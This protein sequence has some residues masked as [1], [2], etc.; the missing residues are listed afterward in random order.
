MNMPL[1]P[2][3]IGDEVHCLLIPIVNG[4]LLLPTVTVAEMIPYRS[5]QLKTDQQMPEWFLGDLSW[6]GLTVPMLCFENITGQSLPES[7]TYNQVAIL[8]NT[9]VNPKLPFFA[10]PAT[11]IP[12]LSR[13]TPDEM[14]EVISDDSTTMKLRI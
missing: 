5:P 1:E 9:G 3:V 6:R 12:H 10:I 13:I 14:P 2:Q 7:E 4:Q 8:N 11:G